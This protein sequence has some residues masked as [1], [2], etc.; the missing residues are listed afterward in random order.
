MEKPDWSKN[1]M[2]VTVLCQYWE[3]DGVW[4][5]VIK[6]LPIAVFGQTLE[7]A[8]DNLR[9]AFHSH[10]TAMLIPQVGE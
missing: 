9:D 6:N 3:E 1:A 7:E 10:M 8:K 4:N 5:G 2:S